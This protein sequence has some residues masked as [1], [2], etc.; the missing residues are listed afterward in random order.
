M[1]KFHKENNGWFLFISLFVKGA[2]YMW[3]YGDWHYRGCYNLYLS[4][5]KHILTSSKK[6]T[7]YFFLKLAQFEELVHPVK[8][9]NQGAV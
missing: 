3:V 1:L 4:I 8:V 5:I 7:I 2:F 9:S 6:S